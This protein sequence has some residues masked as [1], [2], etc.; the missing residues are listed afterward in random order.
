MNDFWKQCA[1][2]HAKIQAINLTGRRIDFDDAFLRVEV[3]GDAVII[4]D[5]LKCSEV[6]PVGRNCRF[7]L[8]WFQDATVDQLKS[9]R[10][11]VL[12]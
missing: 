8:G 5:K 12:Q 1:R 9:K 3:S 2:D 11:I 4:S 6:G 7:E 10:L